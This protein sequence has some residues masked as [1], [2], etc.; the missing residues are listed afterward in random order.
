MLRG[1]EYLTATADPRRQPLE[2]SLLFWPGLR[3]EK[4][5]ENS[6][7]AN[8]A[9]PY[10]G[11]AM[12][13]T[14]PIPRNTKVSLEGLTYQ[15]EPVSNYVKPGHYGTII[16]ARATKGPNIYHVM[17]SDG[18]GMIELEVPASNQIQ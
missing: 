7:C 14:H 10:N 16:R 4:I 8:T 12:S 15:G 6:C 17:I 5:S 2:S 11:N 13:E 3:P 1:T 9:L 18:S